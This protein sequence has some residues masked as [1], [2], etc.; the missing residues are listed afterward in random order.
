MLDDELFRFLEKNGID[1][2]HGMAVLCILLLLQVS[3]THR[4]EE[5]KT[6]LLSALKENV[7]QLRD[8]LL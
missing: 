7:V 2:V 3:N 4:S 8:E 5:I 1:P 6:M